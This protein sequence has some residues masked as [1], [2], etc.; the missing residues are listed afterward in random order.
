MKPAV[1]LV[2]AMC[3]VVQALAARSWTVALNSQLDQAHAVNDTRW[4][5]PSLRHNVPLTDWFNRSDN[6]WYSTISIGTPPQNLTVLFDTGYGDL[7]I[8]QSNCTTCGEHTLFNPN[9]SS[10]FSAIPNGSIM[11]LFG[12]GADSV[13]LS[14]E[15]TASGNIVYDRVAIGP[16][17]YDD[18]AFILC[19]KYTSALSSMPIDGIMGLSPMNVTDLDE[20]SFFWNLWKS[21]Q[22]QSPVFSLYMPADN[23]SGAEITLGDSDPDKYDGAI[24]WVDLDPVA[25]R[26]WNTWV[27]GQSAVYANGKLLSKWTGPTTSSP[28]GHSAIL[29][30]GTAFIQTPDFATASAI[31]AALSPQIRMIDPAGA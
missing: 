27:F 2:I 29:D 4:R 26:K 16:L 11:V 19:D 24:T 14:E 23:A 1:V 7:I 30:T 25:F 12:T 21:G 17:K 20:P 28:D 8:P 10:S 31:Y 9:N 22:L 3:S 18:Q 5:L 6:Q 13:P 15:E